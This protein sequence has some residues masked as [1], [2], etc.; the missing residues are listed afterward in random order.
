MILL[1]EDDDGVREAF[2]AFL[3]LR[4]HEVRGA[5]RLQE[6]IDL[7]SNESPRVIIT[8]VDLGDGDGRTLVDRAR[9]GSHPV[10]VLLLSAREPKSLE[11]WLSRQEGVLALRKPI[12]PMRLLQWLESLPAAEGH[13]APEITGLAV[14]PPEDRGQAE[15]VLSL[16][17]GLTCRP[18][19]EQAWREGDRIRL[20]ISRSPTDLRIRD[21]PETQRQELMEMDLD[22]WPGGA[23]I[24][25]LG[26][27]VREKVE[28]LAGFPSTPAG[29][30]IERNHEDGA[31]DQRAP[32]STERPVACDPGSGTVPDEARLPSPRDPSGRIDPERRALWPD[33]GPTAVDAPSEAVIQR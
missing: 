6:A 4:G 28:E 8:D 14:L 3:R 29:L 13:D 19:V 30:A 10:S 26:F 11:P 27:L 20:R 31:W 21:L 18:P 16:C 17:C 2:C 15:H 9:L 5:C 24:T 25:E 22:L 7:I 1:V 23:G 12:R 33:A 32:D